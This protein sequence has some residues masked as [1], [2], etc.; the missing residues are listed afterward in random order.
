M[1]GQEAGSR[2]ELVILD[3]HTWIVHRTD[4]PD[5]VICGPNGL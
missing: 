2:T 4:L 3:Q 5:Q 1:I